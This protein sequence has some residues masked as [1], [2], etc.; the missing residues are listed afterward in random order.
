MCGSEYNQAMIF[1]S[2]SSS[3]SP[4]SF[5]L[6]SQSSPSSSLLHP[7]YSSLL[8]PSDVSS[9]LYSNTIFFS[10]RQSQLNT[11][12]KCVIVWIDVTMTFRTERV[13]ISLMSSVLW[14][15]ESEGSID[16]V[17]YSRSNQKHSINPC[18]L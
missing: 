3:L 6:S 18:S 16:K 12:A 7:S 14:H 11:P 10:V 1:F 8:S 4:P 2:S 15:T 9:S 17:D 5:P 13:L